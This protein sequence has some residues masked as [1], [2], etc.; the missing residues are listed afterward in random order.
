MKINPINIFSL[1]NSFTQATNFFASSLT[2]KTI[3][4]AG[5]VLAALGIAFLIGFNYVWYKNKKQLNDLPPAPTET[6]VEKSHEQPPTIAPIPTPIVNDPKDF[7]KW[8]LVTKVTTPNNTEGIAVKVC[9]IGTNPWYKCFVLVAVD[10]T[11]LGEIRLREDKDSI[12]AA[13]MYSEYES[14]PNYKNIGRALHEIA[15]RY[16]FAHG[17]KGHVDLDAVDK[18]DGFHFKCGFRYRA[19]QHYGYDQFLKFGPEGLKK[20]S[21]ICEKYRAAKAAGQPTDELEKE[22]VNHEGYKDIVAKAE[23]TLKRKPVDVSEALDYG[24]HLFWNANQRLDKFYNHREQNVKHE[25]C[26]PKDAKFDFQGQMYLPDDEIA[27]W[28]KIIKS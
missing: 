15:I 4:V 27:K 24:L 22:V 9:Q 23:K 14:K 26:N 1:P 8:S 13:R 2:Q 10:G 28:K 11:K 12:C 16:S 21:D 6:R 19:P 20:Y 5:V 17:Y 25:E 3:L 7:T 18:S